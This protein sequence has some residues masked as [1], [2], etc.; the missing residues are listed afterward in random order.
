L[1]KRKTGP[2]ST[3]STLLKGSDASQHSKAIERKEKSMSEIDLASPSS[4]KKDVIF[5]IER[6]DPPA[7]LTQLEHPKPQPEASPSSDP[8]SAI[9]QASSI[10][11]TCGDNM[12]GGKFQEALADAES[13]IA[14]LTSVKEVSTVAKQLKVCAAYKMATLLLLEIEKLNKQLQS[15]A[16]ES[17]ATKQQIAILAKQLASLHLTPRHATI[18]LRM[19]ISRN[20][21]VHNYGVA[22]RFIQ[23]ILSRQP[24]DVH[25]LNE[26][27]NLCKQNAEINAVPNIDNPFCCR[28]LSLVG[29]QEE[30]MSAC[31]VCHFQYAVTAVSV[32]SR[33][34]ICTSST[35]E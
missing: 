32:G 13:A 19:A 20:L 27:L 24:P 4:V 2:S 35:V 5:E 1:V 3:G 30:K 22:S 11:L 28:R 16:F 10:M 6:N 15:S 8:E 9:Q 17:T 25:S 7:A 33:C 31:P 21:D 12:Q 29:S 34:P 14:K 18:C 26:K 23:L